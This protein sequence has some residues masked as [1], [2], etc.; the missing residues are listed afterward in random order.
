MSKAIGR[1]PKAE[2]AMTPAEIQREYLARLKAEGLPRYEA[3]LAMLG[4]AMMQQ[5]DEIPDEIKLRIIQA[6]I[7]DAEK[8][9][10]N[11]EAVRK[12]I[13]DS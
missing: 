4:R 7:K 13:M 10:Y 11:G 8:K 6:A 2:K 12:K 5:L 3:M 9:G 1:P